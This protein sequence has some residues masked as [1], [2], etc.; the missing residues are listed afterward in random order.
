MKYRHFQPE[1]IRILDVLKM[2]QPEYPLKC[3]L[4]AKHPQCRKKALSGGRGLGEGKYDKYNS[5]ISWSQI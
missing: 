5:L 4:R 2:E 1:R 3:E